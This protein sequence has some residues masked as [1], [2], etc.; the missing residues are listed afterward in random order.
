MGGEI[1]ITAA[2]DYWITADNRARAVDG[3]CPT[4]VPPGREGPA[5]LP[6]PSGPPTASYSASWTRR[7]PMSIIRPGGGSSRRRLLWGER[8]S[9]HIARRG[10]IGALIHR[11]GSA[12]ARGDDA[13][14]CPSIALRH[15]ISVASPS[16]RCSRPKAPLPHHSDPGR[17]CCR[18]SRAKW[19]CTLCRA[20]SHAFRTRDTDL[21][22]Q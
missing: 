16:D 10:C 20:P 13:A 17:K 12:S 4:S 18:G 21:V 22:R 2:G 7:P 1:S 11:R 6:E 5:R 15:T 9:S 19:C 3:C 14:A 8:Q